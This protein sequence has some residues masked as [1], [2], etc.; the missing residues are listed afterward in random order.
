MTCI[1]ACIMSATLKKIRPAADADIFSLVRT[2]LLDLVLHSVL[3]CSLTLL[4]LDTVVV[5]CAVVTYRG[6][7]RTLAL[8]CSA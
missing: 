6:L 3:N 8:A 4:L 1:I 2:L 5:H 7:V